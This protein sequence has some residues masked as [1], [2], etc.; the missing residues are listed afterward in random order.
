M[1]LNASEII[2]KSWGD[3]KTHWHDWSVFSLLTV[4]PVLLLMLS[5]A[6]SIFLDS[7]FPQTV[8]A[9]SIIILI[10][11]IIA[12]LAGFWSSLALKHAVGNYVR[13][14]TI[15]HWKEHYSYALK[16]IWPGIYTSFFVGLV[17]FGGTLLLIIPGIIFSLWYS[18]IL[19]VLVLDDKRGWSALSASKA[20]VSG[21]WWATWWRLFIPSLVFG[22]AT[23]L[24]SSG[25]TALLSLTPLGTDATKIIDAVLSGILSALALPLTTLATAHLFVSLQNNPVNALPTEVQPVQ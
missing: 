18:F 20:L 17:V 2:E 23:S 4:A 25:I 13:S 14:G 24:I 21:R 19:Y 12:A 16:Y 22:I 7:I 8:I 5:G 3:Y 15:N 10:L 9:S 11:V 6:L 1:L